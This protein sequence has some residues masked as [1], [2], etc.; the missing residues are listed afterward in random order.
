MR[1]VAPAHNNVAQVSFAY[2]NAG[3]HI[4]SDQTCEFIIFFA[5]AAG[6]SLPREYF[7]GAGSGFVRG[8][9]YTDMLECH[10]NVICSCTGNR[11]CPLSHKRAPESIFMCM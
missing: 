5:K 7:Q 10:I 1:D 3:K 2:P 4:E 8:P 6:A 11:Q 9:R